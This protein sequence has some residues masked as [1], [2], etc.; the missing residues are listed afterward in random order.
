MDLTRLIPVGGIAAIVVL[1]GVVV[2]WR[3]VKDRRSGFPPQD[4]R[5]QKITGK[6]ATYSLVIGVYFMLGLLWVLFIGKQFL[7]Y[8]VL[9]A[10]S[11]LIISSLVFG[12]SFIGLR[13]Y[14][15]RKGDF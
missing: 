6:A 1:V 5:T 10:M 4:E 11:S 2:V 12:L 15:G 14:L 8:A 9:E 3:I 7:G 13:W